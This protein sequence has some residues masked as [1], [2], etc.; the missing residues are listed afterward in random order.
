LAAA[1]QFLGRDA[2]G[3]QWHHRSGHRPLQ[4]AAS[5]LLGIPRRLRPLHRQRHR[6][7]AVGEA[8]V[9]LALDVISELAGAELGEKE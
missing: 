6:N 2:G 3:G 1:K 7:A 5:T 8:A 4:A 9:D